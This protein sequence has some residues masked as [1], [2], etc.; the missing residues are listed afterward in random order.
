MYMLF[1]EAMSGV[2]SVFPS[3]AS[4]LQTTRSWDFIDLLEAN[5][6]ASK[7]SGGEELLKKAGYGQNVT[8][9][10]IDSGIYL[11]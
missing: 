9:A 10:V 8:V 5:W 7:A 11:H 2:V 1:W 4:R 3:R 6:D